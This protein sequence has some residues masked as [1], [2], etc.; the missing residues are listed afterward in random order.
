MVHTTGSNPR[1]RALSVLVP[2]ALAVMVPLAESRA[3]TV[4]SPTS[5]GTRASGIGVE[6]AASAI[7]VNLR[8][9][10]NGTRIGPAPLPRRHHERLRQAVHQHRRAALLTEA[11]GDDLGLPGFPGGDDPRLST[12]AMV[13]SA[14]P[15]G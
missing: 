14:E 4:E 2:G 12:D 15:S 10:W 11:A 13:V 9:A 6:S 5:H 1:S 7:A 8:V 3:M